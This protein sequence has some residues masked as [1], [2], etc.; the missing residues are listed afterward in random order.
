M[1]SFRFHP[2]VFCVGDT[3]Q[4]IFLT[5]KPGMGWVEAG[6]EKYL[7]T[8]NGLMR[9]TDEMHRVTVPR[10]AIDRAGEYAVCYQEMTDRKPYYPE[11]GDTVRRR[12]AFHPLREGQDIRICYL[13]DT[14]GR[15]KEPVACAAQ[16]EFDLLMMG[17]LLY[18]C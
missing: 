7:D 2:T 6:G 16:R 5:D 13:A 9:W 10:E 4:I 3:Y 8:Q 1:S 12:Y 18:R 15:V 14:H 11:H 17:G